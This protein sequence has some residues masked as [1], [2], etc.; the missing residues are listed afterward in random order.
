M[1]STLT[2]GDVAREFGLAT[3]AIRYYEDQGLLP[4]AARRSGRRVY[5]ADIFPRLSVI[6]LAKAAGFTIREIRELLDGCTGQG[7]PGPVWRQLA[8]RKLGELQQSIDNAQRMH[9]ILSALLACECPTLNVCG[10]EAAT[11]ARSGGADIES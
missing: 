7:T 6:E 1:P 11:A 5:S 2:I 3:S 10:T 4:R 9:A 8:R